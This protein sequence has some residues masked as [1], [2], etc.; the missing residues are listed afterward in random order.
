H[1]SGEARGIAPTRSPRFRASALEG[2]RM[3]SGT[4]RGAAETLRP[5][6]R[7]APRLSS[8][9][10]RGGVGA[11]SKDAAP[12]LVNNRG[13]T[14]EPASRESHGDALG[15]DDPEP[16]ADPVDGLALFAEVVAALRR[17]VVVNPHAYVAVSLWV[18][19]SHLATVVR[20]MPRLW[21][22][23]P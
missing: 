12:G 13:G 19:M 7:K 18:A 1:R 23:S 2:T 9:R 14:T 4:P 17:Y 22:S 8:A 21:L 10:G 20:V 11:A 5:L 3:A 15:L 6:P 16:A